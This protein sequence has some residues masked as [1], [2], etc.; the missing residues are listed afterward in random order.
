MSGLEAGLAKMVDAGLSDAARHAFSIYY[1]RLR[2]GETGLLLER[3]LEPVRELERFEGLADEDHGAV[4]ALERAVV[5]K[6]NGGLGTSMGLRRAKSLLEVKD[7]LTFL[8]IIARQTLSIRGRFGVRLPLVL[9]NSFATHDDSL[10]LL[11]RYPQI[12]A[13]VPLAFVQSR[14]P[15]L[16]PDDLE[17]VSW[18][19]DPALEWA[20]P[21]HGDLYTSIAASGTLAAL[22]E[23]DYRYA[24]VSNSDN[25]GAT[26]EPRILAWFAKQGIPFLMEACERAD[27][28]R[29]G[30]HLARR[31]GDG[32]VLRESAQTAEEDRPA[33][34]DIDR[35][36]FF[37]TNN[38]WVDLRALA[39]WLDGHDG[40]LALPLI[41]NQKTVDSADPA[42]PQ[43]IQLETAMG[44]ALEV[45]DAARA[46]LVPRRRF[47]PVKTTDDLLVVRSDAYTLTEEAQLELTAKQ[48]PIVQLD[49]FHYKLLEGFEAHFP[50][51]PP[52]LRSCRE[53]V[54]R[55]DVRFGRNIIIDGIVTIEAGDPR[56][57]YVEDNTTLEG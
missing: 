5:V 10:A 40:V 28:D 17:P 49:P 19:E 38:L 7:G 2:D 50:H 3:E 47:A 21:G 6:V 34:R 14:F 48:R 52:S 12:G 1:E 44:A 53:L 11:E 20:P 26:L 39:E 41:V 16:R 30:G 36:R 46:I 23:R 54:V 8:D 9:M 51:G 33:F 43:V 37:N 22:L 27:P 25:L 57:L 13:D 18:P 35:H 15:R 29:K 42:T 55:G 31:R 32:L 45:F 56:P 24:F 4:D